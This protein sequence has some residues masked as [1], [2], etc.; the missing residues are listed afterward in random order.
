MCGV[1]AKIAALEGGVAGIRPL[2]SAASF[3]SVFN[4]CCSAGDHV[5]SASTIYGGTY[6]LFSVTLLKL[7]IE[8]D[9]RVDQTLPRRRSPGR[10]VRNTSTAWRRRYP[11]GVTPVPPK[12]ARIA[13]DAALPLI[14]DNT[15][16]TPISCRPIG[17]G[18]T[19]THS[20]TKYGRPCDQRWQRDRQRQ[21]FRL[22]SPCGQ[23]PGLT[24]PDASY[25]GLTLYLCKISAS[26][27]ISP[28]RP[29]S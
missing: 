26:W 8:G 3:Y 10:S 9:V 24:R 22:G 17:G 4:I 16:A 25:H 18:P 2:R 20:T 19:S 11:I 12:F 28:R 14:V 1:A 5:V 6:N 15:F 29:R 7:G 27:P 13:R 23:I 21:Q